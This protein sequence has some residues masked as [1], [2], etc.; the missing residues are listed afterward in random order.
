[1]GKWFVGQRR[2]YVNIFWKLSLNSVC[3]SS[4]LVCHDFV[5]KNTG[6][7]GPNVPHTYIS[8]VGNGGIENKLLRNGW[9]KLDR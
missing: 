3:S 2:T 4:A 9:G 5:L 7:A 8:V 6:T 1:M